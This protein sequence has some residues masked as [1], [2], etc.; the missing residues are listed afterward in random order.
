MLL[1]FLTRSNKKSGF[2]SILE[3]LKMVGNLSDRCKMVLMHPVYRS[4]M[5]CSLKHFKFTKSHL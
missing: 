3:L 1:S 5:S 4:T 2:S